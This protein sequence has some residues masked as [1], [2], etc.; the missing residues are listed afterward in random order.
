MKRYIFHISLAIVLVF[1]TSSSGADI[2]FQAFTGE[3]PIPN[4]DAED[5]GAWSGNNITAGAN[6]FQVVNDHLKLSDNECAKTTKTLLPG[7]DGSNWVNYTVSMDV[8]YQDD[9]AIG[10]IFRYTGEESFYSFVVCGADG[11]FND[12]WYLGNACAGEGVCFFDSPRF[13]E[14]LDSGPNNPVLA[15]N[16]PYTMMVRVTGPK[17]EA[18]FG[19]QVPRADIL[20]GATPPKLSEVTDSKYSRGRVGIYVASC[21]AEFA[22]IMVIGGAGAVDAEDKLTTTWGSIKEY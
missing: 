7:I 12:Q 18:F 2:L 5:G 15:Q 6:N 22:N 20:N 9:D 4:A 10:I 17:I 14:P 19:P 13:G 8:W 3:A 16:V 11:N 1:A 21:P